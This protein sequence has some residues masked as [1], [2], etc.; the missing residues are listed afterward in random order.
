MTASEFMGYLPTLMLLAGAGAFIAA[1]FKS[2]VTKKTV[3][4]LM[5]LAKTLEMRVHSLENEKESLDAR[6]DH[7]EEENRVLRSLLDGAKENNELAK[8][9]NSNHSE[10]LEYFHRTLQK[11]DSITHP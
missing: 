2:Q 9:V 3:D 5:D 7:L 10:V 1:Y 8:T 11:I 4:N 6:I